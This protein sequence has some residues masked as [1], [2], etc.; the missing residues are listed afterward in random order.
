[1][2]AIDAGIVV[3]GHL[4]SRMMDER[5]KLYMSQR[6]NQKRKSTLILRNAGFK[7]PHRARRDSW[8]KNK[9]MMPK[10]IGGTFVKV[11]WDTTDRD[12]KIR[13]EPSWIIH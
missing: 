10:P 1:M 4:H 2:S 12:G 11:S 7:D 6:N 5:S 9:G 3:Y 8:E 13:I